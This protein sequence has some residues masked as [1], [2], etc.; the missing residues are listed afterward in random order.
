M[1]FIF[2][3]TAASTNPLEVYKTINNDRCGVME[4]SAI[5]YTNLEIEP[6]KGALILRASPPILSSGKVFTD[7]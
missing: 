5:C 3:T 1:N 7:G 6:E 4:D 2:V